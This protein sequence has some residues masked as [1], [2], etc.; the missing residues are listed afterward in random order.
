VPCW[1]WGFRVVNSVAGHVVVPVGFEVVVVTIA[2][3]DMVIFSAA[4]ET[5]MDKGVKHKWWVNTTHRR[6]TPS[7]D[8]A[9]IGVT[10]SG[11][12]TLWPPTLCPSTSTTP[13]HWTKL[14][15]K[16]VP[17]ERV[18]FAS[19]GRLNFGRQIKYLEKQWGDTRT[20]G[21]TA[22][23]GATLWPPTLCPKPMICNRN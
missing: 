8:V 1:A 12:A 15:E 6:R 10:A 14:M 22:S 20:M 21:V 13:I 17:L 23:G 4:R 11:G 2:V 5:R 7:G 3:F 18:Q 19:S 9:T 16:G